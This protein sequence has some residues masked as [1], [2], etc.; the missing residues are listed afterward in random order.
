MAIIYVVNDKKNYEENYEDNKI[1]GV[2]ST[3]K[4]AQEFCDIYNNDESIYTAFVEEYEL[5]KYIVH[6]NKKHAYYVRMH[7]DGEVRKI[8]YSLD[9]GRDNT[10]W[11][12]RDFYHPVIRKHILILS[13]IVWAESSEQAIEM[14][15][16]FR[17]TIL[18]SDMWKLDT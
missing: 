5:D 15:N 17:L 16:R 14:T 18:A 4:I 13:G 12:E 10:L 3:R 2:F 7:E 8:Y 11:L 9:E 1:I 6:P